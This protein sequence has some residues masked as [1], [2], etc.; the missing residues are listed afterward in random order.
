MTS[1][2]SNKSALLSLSDNEHP[3]PV[4]EAQFLTF[5]SHFSECHLTG[6]QEECEQYML[7]RQEWLENEDESSF[8]YCEA[9][10]CVRPDGSTEFWYQPQAALC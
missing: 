4:T 9:G 5:Q 2:V 1:Y 7:T 8:P 10:V 3:V 6:V